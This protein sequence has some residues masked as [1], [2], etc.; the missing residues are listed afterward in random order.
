MEERLYMQFTKVTIKDSFFETNLFYCFPNT[1]TLALQFQ[2]VHLDMYTMSVI[3]VSLRR[4]S[5]NTK[6]KII[7]CTINIFLFNVV[8]NLVDIMH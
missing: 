4:S 5:Y 3:N 2:H 8:A 1:I 7:T 6:Y